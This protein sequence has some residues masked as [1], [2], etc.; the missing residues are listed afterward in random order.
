MVEVYTGVRIVGREHIADAHVAQHGLSI[1]MG[2]LIRPPCARVCGRGLLTSLW[3]EG[4]LLGFVGMLGVWF[5]LPSHPLWAL[6]K[7][8]R[9]GRKVR[10]EDQGRLED[11]IHGR[12]G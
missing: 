5:V 8:R 1:L 6:A 2:L 11:V 4:D 12:G 9:D 10:C 7:L 3:I